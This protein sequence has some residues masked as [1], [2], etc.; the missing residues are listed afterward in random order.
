M[1]GFLFRVLI[2]GEFIDT[3]KDF[4]LEDQVSE[5]IEKTKTPKKLS[6]EDLAPISKKEQK[7]RRNMILRQIKGAK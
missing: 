2:I 1:F 6:K 4:A 5:V 7:E 3:V